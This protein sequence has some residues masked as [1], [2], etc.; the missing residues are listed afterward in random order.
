MQCEIDDTPALFDHIDDARL[1]MIRADSARPEM[2]NY[3]Q[4]AGFR[5]ESVEKWPGCVEDRVSFI[6]NFEEVI[7]HPDCKH[8]AEEFRL[9]SYKVDKRTGDILPVL[10]DAN[11]HCIDAIGYALTP[12]IKMPEVVF[13]PQTRNNRI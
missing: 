12:L 11:N 6:R 13:M 5:I 4:R 9:Y 7:I 1:Y 10:I 8:T 3:M 2:V